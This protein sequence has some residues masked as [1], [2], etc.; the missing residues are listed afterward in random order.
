MCAEL[1]LTSSAAAAVG[2]CVLS[3]WDSLKAVIRPRVDPTGGNVM[4]LRCHAP[5]TL[6]THTHQPSQGY[7]SP[8]LPSPVSHTHTYAL[9]LIK[10]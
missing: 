4:T 7:A 5:Q 10:N 6:T 1:Q 8:L 2:V 9:T 3:G